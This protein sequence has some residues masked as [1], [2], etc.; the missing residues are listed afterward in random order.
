MVASVKVALLALAFWSFALNPFAH[1]EVPATPTANVSATDT[2]GR[3]LTPDPIVVT[4]EVINIV[5]TGFGPKSAV[6]VGLPGVL[7]P[8]A[9][10]AAGDGSVRTDYRVPPDL[11]N[12]AYVVTFSGAPALAGVAPAPPST[13]GSGD[14]QTVTVVVPVIALYPFRVDDPVAPSS[15]ARSAAGAGGRGGGGTG[16][17]GLSFTGVDVFGA[18]ALGIAGLLVGGLVIA[19]G[20]RRDA[21][22]H[23]RPSSPAG[24]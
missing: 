23:T 6:T 5:A 20:R 18:V 12:G 11:A 14:H 22:G 15:A 13:A 2:R 1:A 3:A 10:A 9:I 17:G 8:N 7:G 19:I 16:T 24:I 4:G 21:A